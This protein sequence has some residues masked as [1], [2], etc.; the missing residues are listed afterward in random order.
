MQLKTTSGESVTLSWASAVVWWAGAS[1]QWEYRLK[2]M[3]TTG[4]LL[5]SPPLIRSCT[6][7]LIRPVSA[8]FLSRPGIPSVQPSYSSGPLQVAR[9]EF[10]TSVVS[11]DIDRAAELIGAGAATVGVAGSGVGIGT[12]WSLA[13]PGTRLW[14]S[15]SSPMPFWALPCL[16]LWGSSVWWLPSSSSSPCEALWKLPIHPCRFR[17]CPMLECA[18]FYH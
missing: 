14:S 6:R 10:Q 5:I 12:A 1:R 4:A 2:N 17:R 15:N 11:Q 8:S 13:M 9:Q 3:Q 16:R 18:N 7:G